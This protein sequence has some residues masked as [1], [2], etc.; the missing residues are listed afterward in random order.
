MITYLK[1]FINIIHSEE[2]FSISVIVRTAN[3]FSKC[4]TLKNAKVSAVTTVTYKEEK[5]PVL[6]VQSN[7]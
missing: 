3:I 1:L 7:F 4:G 2:I 6:I 5:S